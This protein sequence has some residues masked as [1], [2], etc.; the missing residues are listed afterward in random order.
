MENYR[1]YAQSVGLEVQL[2]MT[3]F[4]G[5][6]APLRHREELVGIIWM[7][8]DQDDQRFSEE[9]AETV[10]TFASQAA[11]VIANARRHRDVQRARGDLE[12]LINTAPVGVVVLEARTGTVVSVNQEAERLVDIL[13]PGQSPAELLTMLTLHR[14][15]G[16][17]AALPDFPLVEMLRRGRTI[18]GEEITLTTPGNHSL[19]TLISAAPIRIENGEVEKY[20][21]TVQDMTP[22]RELERLRA[23]FLAMVSHELLRSPHVRQRLD[24]HPP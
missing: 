19:T 12:T 20:V 4:A 10:D 9:D 3:V 6:A 14:A 22:L 15:D 2:P 24:Y 13:S 5:L 11:L 17:E 1:K 7:G 8:H 16:R 18:R 21:I 23:E